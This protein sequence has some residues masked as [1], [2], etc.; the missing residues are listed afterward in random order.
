MTECLTASPV[1]PVG[2][3]IIVLMWIWQISR[4]RTYHLVLSS[5]FPVEKKF[6]YEI[7]FEILY[8]QIEGLISISTE[9]RE[10]LKSIIVNAYH[11][12]GKD[13]LWP[14]RSIRKEHLDAVNGLF[15]NKNIILNKPDK[16]SG[17]VVMNRCDTTDK[18]IA[19]RPNS[20]TTLMWK[21]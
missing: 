19:I 2:T 20:L 7:H 21:T 12:Y 5:V 8:S 15:N 14:Q 18:I 3:Y 16:G 10:E 1:F 9:A 17:R 6:E 11:L 13:K 4:L